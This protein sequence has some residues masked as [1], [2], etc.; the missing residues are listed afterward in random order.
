M[1]AGYRRFVR[2]MLA[3]LM[4]A[5]LLPTAAP[6]SVLATAAN[7]PNASAGDLLPDMKMAFLKDLQM[8]SGANG[9]KV[10]R[11]GTIGWSVGAGPLEVRA[12][13]KNTSVP[14]MAATQRIYND[15]GGWRDV[16]SP[17]VM[18]YS[19]DGHNH[20]HVEQ[21]MIVEL[22]SLSDPSM[23]PLGLR[24][25]GYCLVDAAR[26]HTALPAAPSSAQYRSCG[27]QSST[28]LRVGISVGYGDD[29]PW[30]FRHQWM[31]IAGLP[32][33]RYRICTTVDP[34]NDFI[35]ADERNNHIWHDVD[36]DPANNT[37]RRVRTGRT[38]CRPAASG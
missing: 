12:S 30:S 33:G 19:G 13:R 14:N 38:N 34:R 15:A 18:Y 8:R 37:V 27:V 1:P 9:R 2:T 25:L 5:A 22:Y 28:S 24:K 26:Y 6:T 32:K 36:L 7:G 17:A 31:D 20:W 29:Y 10:L 35:E 4:L 16:A 21:F 23:E 3:L 11:F